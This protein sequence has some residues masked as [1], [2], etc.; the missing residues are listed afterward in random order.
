MGG[1]WPARLAIIC[2]EIA[3]VFEDSEMELYNQWR[4]EAEDQLVKFLCLNEE[5][6]VSSEH[7]MM[8]CYQNNS[9]RP[10]LGKCL[11]VA[12]QGE[13]VRTDIED[14]LKYSKMKEEL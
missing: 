5:R 3:G 6:S 11:K 7:D 13:L 10:G 9:L 2:Q 8:T 4:E 14:M 1:K 12:E